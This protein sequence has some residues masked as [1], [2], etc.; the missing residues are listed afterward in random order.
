MNVLHI[1]R[2]QS[3]KVEYPACWLK[4]STCVF[5]CFC[6]FL[7]VVY[8]YLYLLYRN[9]DTMLLSI[10]RCAGQLAWHVYYIPSAPPLDA[11]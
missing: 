1:S 2:S 11:T 6:F 3:R 8:R 7:V 4:V 10:C 5:F 9:G